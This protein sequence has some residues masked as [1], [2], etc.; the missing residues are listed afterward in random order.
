MC[1]WKYYSWY[2]KIT[3]YSLIFCTKNTYIVTVSECPFG[4]Y[5][6]FKLVSSSLNLDNIEESTTASLTTCPSLDLI[7]IIV[8]AMMNAERLAGRRILL[9]WPLLLRSRLSTKSLGLQSGAQIGVDDYLEEL[10]VKNA[11]I[12]NLLWCEK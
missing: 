7:V 2:R 1:V 9:A 11:K 10:W 12:G 5:N 8:Y 3:W 6:H 4:F